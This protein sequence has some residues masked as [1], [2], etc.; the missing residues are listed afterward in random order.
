VNA[1]TAAFSFGSLE[2]GVTFECALDGGGW[3]VCVSSKSYTGLSD[4][5]HTFAVRAI[6]AVGNRDGS[7]AARSWSVETGAPDTELVMGPSGAVDTRTAEF[8]FNSTEPA[9]FEC[10]LGAGGW[11]ACKS[12][13][14]Y[15]DL[16]DGDHTFLVRAIDA[17]GNVDASPAARSWTVEMPQPADPQPPSPEPAEEEDAGVDPP[18]AEGSTPELELMLRRA[19]RTAR[20]KRLRNL[21]RTG[22]LDVALPGASPGRLRIT[23]SLVPPAAASPIVLARAR[24]GELSSSNRLELV[25]D[26]EARR[27]LRRRARVSLELAAKFVPISGTIVRERLVFRVRR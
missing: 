5:T 23:L 2:S 16:A 1:T 27:H 18:A 22:T 6:D 25:L 10:R 8:T 26:R 19:A 24:S 7:P 3:H 12:P 4:G 17:A 20:E 9:R 14:R 11:R 15:T 21:V 13:H